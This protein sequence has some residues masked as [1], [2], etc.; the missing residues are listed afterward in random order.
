M[1][2][3]YDPQEFFSAEHQNYSNKNHFKD[4]L[5]RLLAIITILAAVYLAAS[6]MEIISKNTKPNPD[7]SK[8]NIII[9]IVEK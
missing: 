9:E 8:L 4:S 7:Y 5:S 6:C 2:N 3:K 1:N